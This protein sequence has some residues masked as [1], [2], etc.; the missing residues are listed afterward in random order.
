MGRRINSRRC[1]PNIKNAVRNPSN[2]IVIAEEDANLADP[3]K[4]PVA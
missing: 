3:S 4:T 2:K 1:P